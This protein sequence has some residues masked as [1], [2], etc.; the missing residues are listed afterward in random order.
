MPAP[1][2]SSFNYLRQQFA[3]AGFQ[4]QFLI[5][6]SDYSDR[7]TKW[8]TISVTWNNPKSQNA[9]LT[10]SNEDGALNAIKGTPTLMR[11]QCSVKVGFNGE[12][13]TAFQGTINSIEYKGGKADLRMD[14][15]LKQLGQRIIGSTADP[16]VYSLSGG[17]AVNSL[18][19]ALVTSFGGYSTT[20]TSAN[21]DIDYPAF[22]SW[23][24][25]FTGVVTLGARFEGITV[26]EA[27]RK[28]ARLTSSAIFLK[29]NKLFLKRFSVTD[30]SQLTLTA[31]WLTSAPALSLDDDNIIN[32]FHTFANYSPDSNYWLIDAITSHGA[33]ISSYGMREQVEK[34]STIWYVNSASALDLGQRQISLYKDPPLK[35]RAETSLTALIYYVGEMVAVA[36]AAAN[37]SGESF[38]ILSTNF[39]MNTNEIVLE[40]DESSILSGFI[41]GTSLLNG[42]D[43][44]S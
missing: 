30:S 22:T 11:S 28:M 39:N 12:L 2:S 1:V 3:P 18:M 29:D 17:Y 16:Q 10:L 26:L 31:S 8:P 14:D 21:T 7:V 27:L 44:L 6:T 20:A 15:K 34:D 42:T 25:V 43:Q 33:S 36:D 24:S 9:G 41:L 35:I 13:I 40:G 37:L 32:R 23:G 4:R 19:W 38:R 5:G